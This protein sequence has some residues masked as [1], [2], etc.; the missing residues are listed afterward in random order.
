MQLDFEIFLSMYST[1][2]FSLDIQNSPTGLHG[3]PI[4]KAWTPIQADWYPKDV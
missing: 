4:K 2:L 3:Y 1:L